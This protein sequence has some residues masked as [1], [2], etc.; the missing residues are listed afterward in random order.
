MKTLE[1]LINKRF[2]SWRSTMQEG[3]CTIHQKKTLYS[4]R[5]K[6]EFQSCLSRTDFPVELRWTKHPGN[7]L[8]GTN[9]WGSRNYD[10]IQ[11]LS[12]RHWVS[13]RMNFE[14]RHPQVNSRLVS[15]EWSLPVVS[16]NTRAF[17]LFLTFQIKNGEAGSWNFLIQ[18]RFSTWR[19]LETVS[20]ML[21]F[22]QLRRDIVRPLIST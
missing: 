3:N 7:W 10:G 8:P 11:E 4:R 16:R 9:A 1:F 17:H 6:K 5:T 20:H 2:S 22:Q 13:S 12:L 14:H 21:I 19:T 18:H 15:L